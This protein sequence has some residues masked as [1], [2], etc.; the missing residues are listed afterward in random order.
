VLDAELE[1]TCLYLYSRQHAGQDRCPLVTAL[2][3]RNSGRFLAPGRRLSKIVDP[4][5]RRYVDVK[6]GQGVT[7]RQC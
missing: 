3:E 6:D 1:L 2:A 4:V 5:E 7:S